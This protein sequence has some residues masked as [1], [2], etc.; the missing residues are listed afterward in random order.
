[1]RLYLVS[2][3]DRDLISGGILD[4]SSCYLTEEGVNT[5]KSLSNKV[6]DIFER[7]YPE[8]F[9]NSLSKEEKLKATMN[10]SIKNS[11]GNSKASGMDFSKLTESLSSFASGMNMPMEDD[12]SVGATRS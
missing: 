4:L 9:D 11:F 5:V 8:E 12:R 3:F 10:R 6:I 2:G 1:M 7:N